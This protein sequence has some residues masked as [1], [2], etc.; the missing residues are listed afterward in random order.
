MNPGEA[1]SATL[2]VRAASGLEVLTGAGLVVAPSLLARLL[3]AS[4]LNAA[5]EATG[6]IAGLVMLCLAAGCWPRA[7][8]AFWDVPTA[9]YEQRKIARQ[10]PPG[11]TFELATIQLLAEKAPQGTVNTAV[12]IGCGSGHK[13]LMWLRSGYVSHFTL[14]E[15]VPPLLDAAKKAFHEAGLGVAPLMALSWLAAA[16][17]IVTGLIGAN[18]GMLLWPAAALHLILAVLLT[19]AWMESRRS[20]G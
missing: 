9:L 17:L 13:E 14:V 15:V 11:M 1:P 6:R 7:A 10:N 12:S 18:V 2:W 20:A 19:R 5:G 3:F 4:D 8:G 16:F